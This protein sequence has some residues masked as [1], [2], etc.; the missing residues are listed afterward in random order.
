MTLAVVI[1]GIQQSLADAQAI[2]ASLVV[3]D[4]QKA[5]TDAQSLLPTP[6]NVALASNGGV[7]SASS[8]YSANYP[9]SGVNNGD[10]KGLKWA[11]GGGWSDGTQ[12][13]YPDWVQILFNGSKTIDHV[14]VCTVQDNDSAPVEPTD[15]MTFTKWGIIDFAVQ[16]WDGAAWVTLG[17]VVGNNLV[18]RTVSFPPYTT[19]RIRVSVTKAVETGTYGG[20]SR[21]TEIEAWGFAAGTAP[22]IVSFVADKTALPVGGGSVTLSWTTLNATSVKLD[23]V[24]ATSPTIV[25]IAQTH[26]FSLVASGQAQP[27]ARATINVSVAAVAIPPGVGVV[28]SKL[29]PRPNVLFIEGF[30]DGNSYVRSQVLVEAIG[31]STVVRA[32]T[33]NAAVG[34]VPIPVAFSATL[35]FNGNPVA[36]KAVAAG[37]T[38]ILFPVDLTNIAEG[39]YMLSVLGVPS[40]WTVADYSL[41]V[42]KG[43]TAAPQTTMP[44]IIGSY[45]WMDNSAFT[46][47]GTTHQS[48]LVPSVYAPV[49]QPLPARD[50]PAFTAATVDQLVFTRLAPWRPTDVYRPQLTR[51]GVLT[52]TNNQNYMFGDYS[53]PIPPW[54]LLDG[55]RGRGTVICAMSINHGRNFKTYVTEPWRQTVLDQTGLVRTLFGW[56]SDPTPSYWAKRQISDFRLKGNW[57]PIP[58]SRWGTR[59]M[60]D[61]FFDLFTLPLNPTAAPIGGEQPHLIGP[62]GYAC[63][64]KNNRVLGAEF[65]PSDHLVEPLMT[66]EITN[67]GAPWNGVIVNDLLY[68]SENVGNRVSVWQINRPSVTDWNAGK[69]RT[70][71]FVKSYPFTAPSGLRAQNG[72]VFVGAQ[73]AIWAIDPSTDAITKRV[74]IPLDD[75]THFM[76]FAI[77]DGTCFERG[78]FAVVTFS[79]LLKR[80]YPRLYNPDGSYFEYLAAPPA[81]KK[82]VGGPGSDI[83]T[84][85]EHPLTYPMAVRMDNGRM[86]WSTIQEGLFRLS[87]ALPTDVPLPPLYSQGALEWLEDGSRELYGDNG[88]GFYGLPQPW[89]KS[90]A[91]DDYLL[92][93]GHV[94]TV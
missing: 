60:W 37:D 83:W 55:P 42:R 46:H 2:G 85:G 25:Q 61:F 76:N 57:S 86:T 90:A 33:Q 43:A 23:G 48:A 30:G 44:V 18:K 77:S 17:S 39:W 27:S 4:L 3:T 92:G 52:P 84:P 28:T 73:G 65:S 29:T 56:V 32:F 1:A 21:I 45:S 13:I 40:G 36:T 81:G 20:Y 35:T 26:A 15:T 31:P 71:T 91:K 82:M 89:G 80:G 12:H 94:R 50:C 79:N 8:Q 19:D 72:I 7:A 63:D 58:Q 54:P 38:E 78:T 70:H 87:R 11:A 51:E 10:R 53:E 67:L 49:E 75:N 22:S 16:G 68:I 6:I 66:E 41:Y 88:F 5:L 59:E 47:E 69:R 34:Q 64:T 14:I 9:V 62:F 24:P 93:N 74:T